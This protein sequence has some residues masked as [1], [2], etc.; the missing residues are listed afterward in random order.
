MLTLQIFLRK[1][2][3]AKFLILLHGH[4]VLFNFSFIKISA[5]NYQTKAKLQILTV[6]L[7]WIYFKNR[8]SARSTPSKYL[9][10]I[11][12]VVWT[13]KSNY[14]GNL[15]NS[16]YKKQASTARDSDSVNDTYELKFNTKI[17]RYSAMSF[18]VMRFKERNLQSCI[19][20]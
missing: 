14:Y 16:F 4:E 19:W 17:G 15:A 10:Q 7:V 1:C 11:C 2:F 8:G 5:E 18:I 13:S 3:L 6:C 12:G 9:S 20:N